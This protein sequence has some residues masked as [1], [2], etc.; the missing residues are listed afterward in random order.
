MMHV[1]LVLGLLGLTS[2]TIYTAAAG[3]CAGSQ[4]AI[5]AT[6]ARKHGTPVNVT[7]SYGAIP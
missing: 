6:T 3:R 7:Q 5:R 2:S 4:Q 1:L